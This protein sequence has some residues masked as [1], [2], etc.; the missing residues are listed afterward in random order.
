[1]EFQRNTDQQLNLSNLRGVETVENVEDV[2]APKGRDDRE[3]L[4][5]RTPW[6]TY[7]ISS[8]EFE[9]ARTQS[10]ARFFALVLETIC[11]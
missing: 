2:E 4:F 5:R 6:R 10:A 11:S 8:F 1:V 7:Q 3:G 9:K